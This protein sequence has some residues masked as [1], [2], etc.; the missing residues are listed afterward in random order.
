VP[1]AASTGA[2][3]C[4]FQFL[5]ARQEGSEFAADCRVALVQA[6]HFLRL[7]PVER[8]VGKPPADVSLFPLQRLDVRRQGL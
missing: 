2:S 3:L 6:L 7:V 8:R 1:A 4:R 5:P